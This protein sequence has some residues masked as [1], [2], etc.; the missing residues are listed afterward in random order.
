MNMKI[1][2]FISLASALHTESLLFRVILQLV[3]ILAAARFFGLLFRKMGQPQVCGEIAAGLILGP[4]LLGKLAPSVYGTIFDPS[5]SSVFLMFSNIGLILLLFVV[6][7]EFDFSYLRTNSRKVLAIS[8]AG[9]VAP[10]CLGLILAKVLCQHVG[11]ASEYKSF[12]LFMATAISIT[13]LPV[14]GRMLLDF[15]LQRTRLGVVTISAAAIDDA[16]GWSALAVVTA[17]V[18]SN[19]NPLK[20]LF[21][22]L[23]I[24]LYGLAMVFVV[25][26]WLVKWLRKVVK[27]DAQ[28]I[29][30]T[31]L[32]VIL[33][34]IF[35]SA[36]ITSLIGIFAVFGGFMMGAILFDQVE[37]REAILHQLRGFVTVFFLP[38]FFTYTGLRT[39]IGS[40]QG[41]VMWMLF[42]MVLLAAI[43]GK[44]GACALA[45]RGTGFSWRD[46]CSV[47]VLMNTRGLMELVVVNIGFE[48]GV[49]PTPVFFML[50]A[51]AVVTTLMTTPLFRMAV[52]DSDLETPFQESEFMQLRYKPSIRL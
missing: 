42:A 49:I 41:A 29:S 5:M 8:I 4:S 15:N 40:M 51:M 31:T 1:E 45:A 43:A 27:R 46:S 28:Q 3:V 44:F 7:L 39:D 30:T 12:S 23:E 22:V 47:G 24:V 6:G 50:V 33:G 19:F 11:K 38:I 34:L 32:S 48:L 9:M 25:R 35:L 20:T 18:K 21:M 16:V 52:K 36:A 13:A 37:F 10:F 14:L 2:A 26:P 17:I